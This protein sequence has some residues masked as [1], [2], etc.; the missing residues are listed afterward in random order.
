MKRG[1]LPGIYW[2]DYEK[3]EQQRSGN[4]TQRRLRGYRVTRRRQGV[5][6]QRMIYVTRE[7]TKLEA[8]AE[9]FVWQ[10]KAA[11]VLPERAKTGPKP[12]H[13]KKRRRA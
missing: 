8:F 9:A 3:R 6:Y 1:N 11:K 4:W 5:V 10:K 2:F 12:F 7:R 13:V